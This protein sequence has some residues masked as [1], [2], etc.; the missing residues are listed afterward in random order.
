VQQHLLAQLDD[1]LDMIDRLF[2]NIFST[3]WKIYWKIYFFLIR[4]LLQFSSRLIASKTVYGIKFSI[5]FIFC[6]KMNG[7]KCLCFFKL[8]SMRNKK[9]II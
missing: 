2:R 7:K 9:I 1:V 6:L 5:H 4:A 3:G 8:F